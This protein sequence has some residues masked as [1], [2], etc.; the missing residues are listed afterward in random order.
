MIRDAEP[1]TGGITQPAGET[2]GQAPGQ[3][4]RESRAVRHGRV[5]TFAL[6]AALVGL[7][8]LLKALV[9]ALL[10]A[11]G[12]EVGPLFD[13]R[14]VTNAGINFGLFA[15]H[16]QLV[17]AATLAVGAGFVAYV[18]ARPPRGWW[19]LAGFALLLG[20]GA[21]NAVDRLRLGAVVDYL[22]ITPFVGYL[23]FADLA[24]GAGVLMLVIDSFWLGPRRRAVRHPGEKPAP[25]LIRDRDPGPSR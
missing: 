16:P 18:I 11:G 3:P 15:D 8:Q 6:G 21:G 17:L 22:N 1:A 19:P 12:A 10:P 4:P 20:G 14:H 23:N 2:A 9:T 25:H 13:L 5:W 24:I 7:D